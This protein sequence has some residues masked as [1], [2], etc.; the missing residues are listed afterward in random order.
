MVRESY[1]N[2]RQFIKVT[3]G[4]V[5]LGGIAG[6]AG[7][8]DGGDTPAPEPTATPGGSTPTATEQPAQSYDL[9]L[10]HY[11][12]ISTAVPVILCNEQ[13]LY[14]DR[15]IGIDEITSFSGGGTTIRGVVTGGLPVGAGGAPAV[16]QAWKAGAPVNYIGG[17]A[18]TND[19]DV[20]AP[21]DSDIESI[22]DLA[23]K[24]VGYT[25]PGGSSHAMLVMS[26]KRA[27]G[28]SVDDVTLR[29]MGGL[30][31]TITGLNEGAIDAGWS[32]VTVSIPRVESGEWKRIFGTWEYASEIPNTVFFAGTRTIEENKEFFNQ[33]IDAH[34]EANEM[35]KEDPSMAAELWAQHADNITPELGRKVI[36]LDLEMSD[37]FFGVGWN[38]NA[39]HSLEEMMLA[40]D[41]IES[42]PD[43]SAVVDQQFIPEDLQIDL[44]E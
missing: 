30:G 10:S 4:A 23:G 24:S 18:N 29:A 38:E 7:G 2:R 36:E 15:N 14:A 26:L 43:W 27:E 35:I 22:Q 44:P 20:V 21:A 11:P 31:E 13:G 9:A 42:P 33:F 12:I 40:V 37:N 16:T 5:A 19:I 34:M 25:N 28:I 32:N 1:S 8:S 17:L 39:F 6:C 3:S 41:L